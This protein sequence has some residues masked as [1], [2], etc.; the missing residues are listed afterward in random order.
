MK[1]KYLENKLSL[2]VA[3]LLFLVMLTS[4]LAGNLLAKYA[5]GTEN[6]ETAQVA[7]FKITETGVMEIDVTTEKIK[8]GMT[9]IQPI[10]VQN[11]SEVAVNYTLTASTT[12]NLPLTLEMDGQQGEKRL[13]FSQNLTPNDKSAHE[14]NLRIIWPESENDPKYIKMIDVVKLSL[15]VVQID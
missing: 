1:R 14:Y 4:T 13:V 12:G 10:T 7:K 11:E 15:S 6:E 5:T 3:A 2:I 9:I 8:P